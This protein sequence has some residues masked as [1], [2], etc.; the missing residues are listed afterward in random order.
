LREP[1]RAQAMCERNMA[2][3]GDYDVERMVNAYLLVYESV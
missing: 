1:D 3:A 2:K